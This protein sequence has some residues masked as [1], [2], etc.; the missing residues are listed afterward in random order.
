MAASSSSLEENIR[1]ICAQSVSASVTF[2]DAIVEL[3]KYIV[4]D[5]MVNKHFI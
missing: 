5:E 3:E 1:K 2:N 4:K